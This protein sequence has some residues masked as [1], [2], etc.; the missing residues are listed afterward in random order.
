MDDMNLPVELYTDGS[1]SHNPGAGGLAYVIRYWEQSEGSEIPLLKDIEGSAGFRLT[2]NNRMEIMAAIY[3][4]KRIIEEINKGI[5]STQQINLSSDSEYLCNAINKN[6]IVRWSE[7]NWMTSAFQGRKSQPV[8]NK[9][10]W[11]QVLDFQKELKSKNINLV[12]EHV[13]AHLDKNNKDNNYT[14]KNE[15]NDKCDKLAVAATADSSKHIIDE[16]YE[17]TSTVYNRR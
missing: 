11:I 10:L 13:T 16:V 14:D 9:D 3:G 5:I 15:Y 6:W 4:V 8:K 12:V 17:K 7:N 2:T 1:C